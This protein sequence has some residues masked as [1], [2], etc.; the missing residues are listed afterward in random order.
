MSK[1]AKLYASYQTLLHVTAYGLAFLFI[2]DN[3]ALT[4]H[5]TQEAARPAMQVAQADTQPRYNSDQLNWLMDEELAKMNAP[6]KKG[7]KP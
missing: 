1:T 6:K 7:A 3:Y 5:K 4:I 2:Q